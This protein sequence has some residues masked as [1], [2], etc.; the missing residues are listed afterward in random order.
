MVS[1]KTV[2]IQESIF[3]NY[4]MNYLIEFDLYINIGLIV[5]MFCV[6]IFL[7]RFIWDDSKKQRC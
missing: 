4:E 2:S 1:E 6:M 7:K 3:W 5:Y